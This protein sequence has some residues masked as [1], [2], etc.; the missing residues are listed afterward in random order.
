MKKLIFSL[1][2]CAMLVGCGGSAPVVTEGDLVPCSDVSLKALLEKPRAELAELATE[3]EQKIQRQDQLRLAGQLKFALLSQ[4][5]LPLAPPIWRKA[6]FSAERGFSVPPYLADRLK[7][8]PLALHLARH[9]DS[10]AALLLAEP[11]DQAAVS[12]LKLE[13]NYPLEWTRLAGLLLH[14]AQ[15]TL[16]TDNLEGGKQLLALHLE[17]RALLPPAARQ[18]ALGQALLPRGLDTLEQASQAWKQS[19]RDLLAQQANAFLVNLDAAPAWRWPL[20]TSRSE[21]GQTGSGP[22]TAVPAPLRALD[23]LALPVPHDHLDSCWTF[24]DADHQAREVL[25]AYRTTQVDYEQPTQWV[26]RLDMLAQAKPTVYAT[27]TPGNPYVGGVIQIRLGDAP[28][29]TLPRDFGAVHLDRT[30]EQNRRWFAWKQRGTSIVVKD[31]KALAE[32]R[33]PLAGLSQAALQRAP[34]VDLLAQVRFSYPASPKDSLASVAR[35]LWEKFGAGQLHVGNG[36][37]LAWDDGRTRYVLSLPN[38]KDQPIK[39]DVSDSSGADIAQRLSSAKA[40]DLVDRQTRLANGRPLAR[41]PRTVDPLT[42]GMK[43]TEVERMLPG[44]ASA[45][46]RDIP[47][48]FMAVYPGQAKTGSDAVL[49]MIFAR[50]DDAG[51]LAELRIRY[52]DHP[53]NKPGTL[54][55][56]LDALQV[57]HGPGEVASVESAWSVDLPARKGA[58]GSRHVWHDD[59]TLL[60]CTVEG[61]GLEIAMRDCPLSHPEG[62]PLP[63]LQFLP[64]GPEGIGLGTRRSDLLAQGGTS[65]E[66]A[67]LLKMNAGSPYDTALVWFQKEKATRIIARHR[68]AAAK[69]PVKHLQEA[70]RRE[71]RSLGWPWRQDLAG[72]V[73][74]S[75]TTHDALT[76]YRLFWEED[77]QGTFLFSEWREATY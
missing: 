33:Q 35:P 34:D 4:T 24:F 19:G 54:R 65:H 11:S 55:K 66:G 22:G 6:R 56:K 74:Q 1:G 49:R 38:S 50:F 64:R 72:A 23:L 53:G 37:T 29:V 9:G 39:V 21:L 2:C 30:F 5:R 40:R 41:L 7:D 8:T 12:K 69:E 71:V 20:P 52:A 15:F 36:L 60:T 42:L 63:S 27:L 68:V 18:G 14:H 10:E 32:V 51:Q 58:A 70:W 61:G 13:R 44:G 25:L 31:A 17:L 28:P 26:P 48:G 47:Q 77:N 76:R 73:P 57:A 45:L 67:L 75:W 3:L 59:G 62:E 43:R 46:R 16:A